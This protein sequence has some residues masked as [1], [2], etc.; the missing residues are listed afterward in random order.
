M[1]RGETIRLQDERTSEMLDFMYTHGDY[2]TDRT[3]VRTKFLKEA[4]KRSSLVDIGETLD[5]MVIENKAKYWEHY[6]PVEH[7]TLQPERPS[8][9]FTSTDF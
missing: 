2:D 4:T 9:D 5:K 6:D 3:K 7:A 8:K 1:E